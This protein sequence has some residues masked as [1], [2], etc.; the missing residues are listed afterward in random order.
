[1]ASDVNISLCLPELSDTERARLNRT[2]LINTFQTLMELA[3]MLHWPAERIAKLESGEE[4]TTLVDQAIE[5]GR[6]VI[7]LGPHIGNWE[8]SSHSLAARYPFA[9]LYRPPRIREVDNAIRQSRE[10]M[11]AE[12]VPATVTGLKR[13]CRILKEGG[14]V[15]I[16]PDQEPLK[17][18]GV[19]APL[20]GVSALT[21]TLVGD[22]VRLFGS[23]V[24]YGWMERTGQGTFHG[25]F[26]PAPEGLDAED[27]VVAATQLNLGV[28][29]V[30][31]ACP[32]QYLWAYKRFK[33]RP[34]AEAA[35]LRTR[36]KLGPEQR[37]PY[38]NLGCLRDLESRV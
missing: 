13:V 19:F 15:G 20:F 24:I 21:M 2:A 3:G 17:N 32:D 26:L 12:L 8:L 30:V 5:A 37:V 29:A 1:M 25:K 9:A 11:G 4:D 34:A 23:P 22:L 35:E 7:L 18:S 36:L 16:L 28:E 38:A 14:L 31:R 6:G 33:S 27:K 10:R